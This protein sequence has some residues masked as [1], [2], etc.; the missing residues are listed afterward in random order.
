VLKIIRIYPEIFV[1]AT[2]SLEFCHSKED[3]RDFLMKEKEIK[4]EARVHELILFAERE[5][6]SY[7]AIRNGSY[8]AENYLDDY[9]FKKE[10]LDRQLKAQLA[11][12]KISPVFYYMLMQDIGEGDLAKRIGISR[13]K[14]RK[15]FRPKVFA[16]LDEK[17]LGK[18]A[19][20]FGVGVG[21]L[22]A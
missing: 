22:R 15:H 12:G 8:M 3:N 18:Y 5:D 1:N 19:V 21:G 7:G 6:K 17:T 11:D 2:K 9:L 14:L 10:N 16:R 13:R 20:V 4:V